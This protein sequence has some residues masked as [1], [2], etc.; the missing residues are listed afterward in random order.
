[1]RGFRLEV[2]RRVV[3]AREFFHQIRIGQAVKPV[4]PHSLRF[5]AARD[6]QQT[7]NGWQVLVKSRIETRHLRQFRKAPMKRLGQQNL[8][9][10]MLRIEWGHLTQILDHSP[11]DQL[12]V[13][14]LRSAM[15]HA[16]PHRGQ[17]IT[18]EPFLDPI[19][20]SAHRRR[21]VR[22]RH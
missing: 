1:V 15:H 3:E 17:C 16:M 20:Q 10:Q 22:R 19:H 6:R 4:P 9:G 11:G 18:P 13:R 21:V 12:R 8:L 7:G 5:V 2:R 14:V